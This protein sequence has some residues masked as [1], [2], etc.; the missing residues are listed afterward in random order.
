MAKD[1]YEVGTFRT[2]QGISVTWLNYTNGKF[3]PQ[4]AQKMFSYF[5][6][7]V[8]PEFANS[9]TT[10]SYN[11]KDEDVYYAPRSTKNERVIFIV[12]ENM[13]FPQYIEK[14]K[15]LGVTAYGGE[16]AVV[17]Y[18][19][20]V[21]FGD[22]LFSREDWATVVLATETCQQGV[23]ITSTNPELAQLTQ[24]VYCNSLGDAYVAKQMDLSYEEYDQFYNGGIL[25][26]FPIGEKRISAKRTVFPKS[27]YASIPK[28]DPVLSMRE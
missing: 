10:I 21:D 13:P 8:P 26:G 2:V 15:A 6:N 12:P 1:P 5:Y 16:G 23:R 4:A 17:S 19:K 28:I 14:L 22:K 20:V 24:E 11:G 18:I 27:V 7:F 9:K 3:N 25:G